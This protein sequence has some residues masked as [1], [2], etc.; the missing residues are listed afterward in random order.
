M[1]G[2]PRVDSYKINKNSNYKNFLIHP[3]YIYKDEL[4]FVYM[5]DG[6]TISKTIPTKDFVPH[7][8]MRKFYVYD[9]ESRRSM[10]RGMAYELSEEFVVSY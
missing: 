10:F 8:R 2:R 6:K 4:T 7:I 1:R 3:D 5:D 9:N